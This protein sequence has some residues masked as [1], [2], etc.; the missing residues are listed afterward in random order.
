MQKSSS[1][2]LAVA[3]FILFST[4]SIFASDCEKL[5]KEARIDC[6]IDLLAS[7]DVSERRHAAETF[8]T[9]KSLC[10]DRA[11][12][13]LIGA[14]Q[15]PD[16]EVRRAVLQV[17]RGYGR[18]AASA[19][20]AIRQ[21]MRDLD[22]L[23]QIYAI[24][25]LPAVTGDY[26]EEDRLH[27]SRLSF[28]RRKL[29]QE[30]REYDMA[31]RHLETGCSGR[32]TSTYLKTLA[33]HGQD[34]MEALPSAVRVFQECKDELSARA[35][36][37]R[38]IAAIGPIETAAPYLFLGLKDEKGMVREAAAETLGKLGGQLP[39]TMPA[40]LEALGDEDPDV[41]LAA[42]DALCQNNAGPEVAEELRKLR[43]RLREQGPV[44]AKEGQKGRCILLGKNNDVILQIR[45]FL[46]A[47]MNTKDQAQ[48]LYEGADS[49]VYRT[50]GESGVPVV[51]KTARS[52]NPPPR[53][54]ARMANEYELLK[55]VCVASIRAVFGQISFGGKPALEMEYVEGRTVRQI[56]AE[57][58]RSVEA[59][60]R[61]AIPMAIA[62]GDVHRLRIIHGN[63]S[64]H[65]ILVNLQDEVR[66]DHR[67]RAGVPPDHPPGVSDPSGRAGG[68]ARVHV[69]GTD[70]PHEPRGGFSFR[71]VFLGRGPVRN[72][73]GRA[74]VSGQRRRGAGA[75][76]LGQGAPAP[77]GPASR[78]LRRGDEAFV[79]K[80]RRPLSFGLRPCRRLEVLQ[81]QPGSPPQS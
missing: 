56:A 69:A 47:D 62:L 25:A 6:L 34:A 9:W 14:V 21:A 40:L 19:E 43:G 46:G 79:Q 8:R 29:E 66:Q 44:Q 72:G 73:R 30:I 13:A 78:S 55:D 31:I 17:L 35:Q 1:L 48:L 80:R 60:L 28:E 74:A 4:S 57:T 65:N 81:G 5:K 64:G 41:V 16:V 24:E 61:A 54:R 63:I 20:P 39:E 3:L 10:A 26:S 58:S 15:D 42:I 37:L 50:T 27:S 49:L 52:E 12:P 36:A 75:F 7:E 77:A 33:K 11:L 51:V 38:T 2:I 71:P 23:V 53:R 76:P 45:A 18:K 59:F 32:Y 68:V 67:F 22:R 70:R